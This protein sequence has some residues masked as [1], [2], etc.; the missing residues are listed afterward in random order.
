MK[1]VK[2]RVE[3]AQLPASGQAF[4]WDDEL[5]GFGLRV[6]AS[7]SKSYIAQGRVG[8]RTRRV[9]IG[10]HGRWTCDEARRQARE[11]LR[12]MD[13][14]IDP[15]E[16]RQHAAVLGVTLRTVVADYLRD[17]ALKP[18]SKNDIEKHLKTSFKAWA[19]RPAA[20]ITRNDVL[21]RFREATRSSAAQANQAFVILRALLNYARARYRAPDGTAI[22]VENPVSVLSEAKLWNK[23]R[24]RTSRIPIE[25]I[26]RAWYHLRALPE[27]ARTKHERTC[28]DYVSFLLLTGARGSEAAEL[29]WDRVFLIDE[30]VEGVSTWHLPDPKNGRP[31]TFPLCTELVDILRARRDEQPDEEAF[32]F[33]C[34]GKSGHITD[35]RSVLD[36]VAAHVGLPLT[37]HDLRRTFT[38]LALHCGSEL[39]KAELLTGHVPQT[40]T[41]KHYMETSDLRYLAFDIQTISSWV[42]AQASLVEAQTT[43]KNVVAIRASR[44]YRMKVSPF[45]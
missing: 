2:T 12:E 6:T 45:A 13:L 24:A 26:G 3:A 39:W 41:L 18:N 34:W 9:T 25:K 27:T 43:G 21:V 10:T 31:V 36:K 44:A 11:I 33:P 1:L 17:R 37:R 29:T 15:Q 5:R 4:Y 20:S 40:V 35:A 28:V 8:V 19:D 32:V 42:H 14:G 16:K 7:G 30:G 23:E 22:L 38:A